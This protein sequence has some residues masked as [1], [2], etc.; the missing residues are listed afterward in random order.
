EEVAAEVKIEE[1][2]NLGVAF[3]KTGMLDEAVR[4]FRRV[5]E[6]RPDDL[7]ARFYLGLAH[8]R[9]GKWSEALTHQRDARDLCGAAGLIELQAIAQITLASYL[10]GLDQRDLAKRELQGAL[11]LAR[12][13]NLLRIESQAHLALGLL[14]GLDR[15][16]QPAMQ[17]YVD[18]A[19]SAEAAD[20][21]ILAIEAWRMAGQLAGQI[22]Q[23]DAAANALHEALRVAT[24]VPVEARKT[25]SAPEAA[26]QLAVICER[27][28]MTAQAASLYAQADA[29]EAGKETDH[30]GE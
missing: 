8:L 10:S 12:S 19:K 27:H 17:S 13:H 11:A 5:A 22:G 28:G 16:Y 3:Y 29:M 18:A 6:L 9:L 25:T 2:R 20:E 23:D 7:G 24:G 30:V 26:R 1:H 4:E 21:P 14:H 15:A